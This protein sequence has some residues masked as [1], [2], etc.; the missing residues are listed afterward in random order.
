MIKDKILMVSDYPFVKNEGG[1]RG[2][3]NKCIVDNVPDNI[4]LINNVIPKKI[5]IKK[6]LLIRLDKIISILKNRKYRN[7]NLA[8]KFIK[9][10]KYKFLYFHD[11][12][13]FYDVIHLIQKNQIVIFQS[14][15]PETP[16]EEEYKLGA[17][18][19]T[20]E[21]ILKIEKG[22]FERTNYLIL[23]NEKC[24]VIYQKILK[25]QHKIAYLTTGI[26]PITNLVKIPL[27]DDKI[28][29]FYIGR[30]NEIKGFPL[31]IKN[32]EEVLKVRNDL[33]LFIA[34]SGELSSKNENIIDLGITHRAYDWI[35]SVDYVISLNEKSYFD[36]N[37]IEAIAIN[38]PLIMTTTEGHEFFKNRKGI[39]S[40]DEDNLL[41][42]LTNKNIIQK[43]YKEK[44]KEDL[45]QFY[46][47][48][49]SHLVY[50]QRLE[51]LASK[52][53]IEN[54]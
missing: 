47:K 10:K 34:G 35:N 26:K 31:L 3:F 7:K 42:T 30:R 22:V 46:L 18:G 43:K 50:K 29:I 14:H 44:R 20:Y 2:Y 27:K 37:I 51:D 48:E 24:K 54:N 13:S 52:I 40:V 21:K 38:T 53:I 8:N 11:M 16:S 19:K 39:I 49:L 28:N 6:K 41:A 4:H 17:R 15:S 25:A 9:V 1:P 32:F 23:P 33:R 12:Y 36:L 5:S 45:Q